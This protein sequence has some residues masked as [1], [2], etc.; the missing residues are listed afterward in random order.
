M[1]M[2]NLNLTHFMVLVY[3]P[4]YPYTTREDVVGLRMG[5]PAVWTTSCAARCLHPFFSST[6]YFPLGFHR[7][8]N[9]GRLLFNPS[10]SELEV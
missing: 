9:R 6:W 1:S 10:R 2:P 5:F 7:D 8:Y 3:L 4:P